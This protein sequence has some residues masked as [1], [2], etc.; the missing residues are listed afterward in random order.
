VETVDK[1]IQPF[2]DEVLGL[3]LGLKEFLIDSN[4]NKI[5][6]PR[7]LKTSLKRLKRLSKKHS[8]T[9]LESK[10]REKKKLK[11]AKLHRRVANQRNDFLHKE[12]YKITN[13]NQVGTIVIE[14]L[15]IKNMIKNRALS[16]SI[17]D[18]SW[19]RFITFL[20]YKLFRQ[21]KKLIKIGTFFPSSKQ[22]SNCNYI[23]EKLTLSERNWKC[24]KCNV[25]HDRDI[26]AAINIRNEG[27]RLS[28][29]GTTG[30]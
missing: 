17:A 30:N 2:G 6:N 13:D 25:T 29:V 16:R 10:N 3:D 23:N 1:E 27:I 19:S 7:F 15:K 5:A 8:K 21:G 26:N 22:C 9:K 12:S 18:V 14:T 28:T 4:G 20:E 24:S 11:L